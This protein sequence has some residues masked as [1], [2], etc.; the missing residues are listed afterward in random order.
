MLPLTALQEGLMFHAEYSRQELDVYTTQL[1]LDLAGALDADRLRGAVDALLERHPNLRAA[2]RYRKSG[3]PVQVIPRTVQLPWEEVELGELPAQDRRAETDRRADRERVRPFDLA[4]PPL[5]RFALL[6]FG[7]ES[8]TL[9]LTAHQILFDGWSMPI[10]VQELFAHYA[11]PGVRLPRVTPY[12]SYLAHLA[13]QDRPA[14]ELAWQQALDGVQEPT[15]LTGDV[16]AGQ[17]GQQP[18]GQHTVELDEQALAELTGWARERGLTLNTVVQG[19]WAATLGTLTGLRDVLFGGTVSGR[20]PELPGVET[21]VGLFI[22]SLPVRVDLDPARSFT[23]ILGR[24]QEQQTALLPHQHL[25]LT[26]IQQ[27]VGV[28]ELFD[29]ALVF[30][31]YPLDPAALGEP[32]HGLRLVDLQAK[33]ANHYPLSL[34]ALPGARL[35]LQIGHDPARYSAAAAE[36]VAERLLHILR[37]IVAEPDRPLGRLDLLL[38]GERDRA[39]DRPAPPTDG[40]HWTDV[41]A[42]VR[43]FA[44]ADPTAVAVEDGRES[45]DYRELAGRASAVSGALLAA[46]V[47]EGPVGILARPGARFV[48]AVLGVLG[49]GAGWLPLDVTAPVRRSATLAAEAGISA[50]LVEPE[51]S[52]MAAELLAEAGPGTALLEITEAA[53]TPTGLV[54]LT[55]SGDDL[56]YVIFTSGSTGKPKG[57]MVHRAGM[58]N[59]LLAKVADLE[60]DAHS[61]LIHNAPVTFDISVWQMLAALVVGGRLRVVDKELAADPDALFGLVRPESVTVL[62][63]VPSLLRAALDGWDTGRARPELRSLEWL[64]VTGEALPAEL[65]RRWF[66]YYPQIPLLNA[67]GPTECSDDVTHAAIRSA[68]EVAAVRAPIGRAIRGTGLYVLNDSLQPLPA[69]VPGELYVGGT[70]V[71]RG[72]LAQPGRTAPVF[73]ADPFTDRPGARMYRTGDRVVRRPDGQLEFLERRDHQVKIRGHRIEPGEVE[74]VLRSVAGVADAVVVVGKDS[75]GE[76]RLIGYLAGPVDPAQVRAAVGALLP[77]Y[78]VPAALMALP[79]LPLTANGKVDRKALPP[80]EVSTD[81]GRGPRTPQEEVLC[82]IFAEVLGHPR[83]GIDEDFFE[84]GGHSLLATRLVSRV[85]SLLGVELAIRAVFDAPTVAALAGRLT[86]RADRPALVAS[87][88][89]ERLPLSYAQQRLWFLNRL[90]GPAGTYNM[91]WT[92]RLEGPL[93]RVA[94]A[95]ALTDV[96][97]RHESLRTLYPELDGHPHQLVLA[98]ELATV[99]LSVRRTTEAELDLAVAD[100]AAQGFDLGSEPP[101]RAALFTVTERDHL[102]ALSIHHIAGD[103]WSNAP[104]SRD[105]STAYGARLAGR[106]PQWDALA[107]QYADYALWQRELLGDAADPQSLAAGQIAFWREELAG[108]PDELRLPTDFPR[109]ATASYRGGAVCFTVSAAVHSAALALARSTGSSLFMVVQ[110]ALATLF[111]TLGAGADIPLGTPVAGRTDDALDELVGFFVNTLVLRTDLSGDPTFRELLAR[112]RAAD[113]AAFAHQDVPFE[114]LVDALG[115]ARSLARQPLFQTLLAFQNNAAPVLELPGLRTTVGAVDT[116]SAKFDLSFELAESFEPERQTP[117]GLHGRLEFSA[118]LFTQDGAQLLAERL[119]HLLARLVEQPDRPLS[120]WS[121]LLPGEHGQLLETGTGPAALSSERSLAELLEARAA[122]TPSAAALAFE[123]VALS[124]TELHERANRLARVLVEQG[125]AP[126][127]LVAIMLPRSVDMVVGA[128]AVLKSGAAY[129]PIDPSYPADRIG[130]MLK[131][132]QPVLALGLTGTAD[133]VPGLDGVPLLALDAPRT[134]ALLARTSGTDLTAADRRGEP[135]PAHAAYA[136]YTSGSTGRPKGV[137]VPRA[138]L[139]NHLLDLA[140]R[141]ELAAGDSLLSVT[142][143]G[144]DIANLELLVPLL[145]G[146]RL[147]LAPPATVRD[148][149]RLAELIRSSGATVMQATPTLWHT[150]VSE[151]PDALRGLHVLTGGEAV[152]AALAEALDGAAGQVSNLYGPTETTIWSVL[153]ELG[154]RAEPDHLGAPPIGRPLAGN[155]VYLLDPALQPVPAGVAGELYIAGA[156]LARGYLN[157]AALTGQRFVADPF[158][159]PGTRMY[160]TGDLARWLPDGSLDYLGRVDHQVKI[161]GFRIELGEIEAVLLD[162]PTVAQATVVD[163]ADEHGEKRLFGYLVPVAGAELDL[164]QLRAHLAAGLPDYMVP[165]GFVVLDAFPL[166]PNGKVDRKALPDPAGAATG[167]GG[168]PG[169][170]AQNAVEETLLRV[171]ADVLGVDR[172]GVDDSFFELGGDSLRSIRLVSRARAAG[173][174]ITPADVFVHRTPAG[175]AGAATRLAAASL[176]EAVD[177]LGDAFAKVLPIRPR[178]GRP[179]LFCVHGAVGLGWPFLTLAAEIDPDIP[180]Y[181]FQAGGILHAE[182]RPEGVPGIAEE[183]VARMLEIQPDGPYHIAGWSFGGLVAHEMAIQLQASGRQVALLANLDGFPAAPAP[184]TADRPAVDLSDRALLTELL[185]RA[186]AGPSSATPPGTELDTAT[187]LARLEQ[188]GN[189]LAELDEQQLENLLTLIRT[190]SALGEAHRP[191]VYRGDLLLFAATRALSANAPTEAAWAGH[192]EG[193]IVRHEV[194]SDHDSMLDPEPAAAIAR[195]LSAALSEAHWSIP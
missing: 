148:P 146:A 91:P 119:A 111:G 49:A 60:L 14:A 128:L 109:R 106:A 44:L 54:P 143:F 104:L 142:T 43:A 136:I 154:Q 82:A 39:L 110:A 3:E 160:R 179:P 8:S 155:Q 189:P 144:F 166:T 190:H 99:E 10:V 84:L 9:I 139:A 126:D 56:A 167:A 137:V 74:A 78:M 87:A 192:V 180:V 170:P 132:A 4:R 117:A 35:R 21:M 55:G 63:V 151:Q 53:D 194:D 48:S 58:A 45:L 182:S 176:G 51:L 164:P 25:S 193:R 120:A 158:G 157:R 129:L 79:A 66:D 65:C 147:V 195:I 75:R 73:V 112:V 123:D 156:G 85:R 26:R 72:Y 28:G 64:V 86:E 141:L 23:E 50:L 47:G 27:L 81:T 191:G 83:V 125:A 90:E 161:R 70:G 159:P 37:T 133:A 89:P 150:L 15:R 67:Y 42:R 80:V 98:P 105:L 122:A 16:V 13:A 77:E 95:S 102:L 18:P 138:A 116:A 24:L 12:K 1:V 185:R 187:V 17:A 46:G 178:G 108:L 97:G 40:Q 152:S 103:G 68:D 124:Y 134:A 114:R 6:R 135:H 127:R 71:G 115:P 168:E 149:A 174:G 130:Y 169:R 177:L 7:P 20:P 181:G 61:V 96:V 188:D 29:S 31:N 162:H 2:F 38:P 118:D 93:D 33:D 145:S 69:G 121:A 41:V 36:T 131:D 153:A 5:L 100:F 172:V 88:R 57:A 173:L 76:A 59:H 30:E 11:D 186:G 171:F 107:V 32:V 184:H 92:L 163:R 140:G 101:L 165:A 34:M 19:A 22:N 183:Y 52:S 113:L 62:E 94:L 175:L